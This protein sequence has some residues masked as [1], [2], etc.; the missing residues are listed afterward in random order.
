VVSDRDDAREWSRTGQIGFPVQHVGLGDHADDPSFMIDN[1]ETLIRNA[2][3]LM[4]ISLN[5]ASFFTA[6][7]RVVITSPR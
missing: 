3:I 5:A 1:R 2:R 4:I 7:T 6:T